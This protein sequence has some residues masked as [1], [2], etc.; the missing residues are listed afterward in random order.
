M[1]SGG[2]MDKWI[3]KKRGSCQH[4]IDHMAVNG[5]TEAECTD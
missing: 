1:T 5:S 3:W 2:Q 4:M